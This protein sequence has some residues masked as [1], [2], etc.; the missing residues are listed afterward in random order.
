MTAS[1]LV[2][3]SDFFFFGWRVWWRS[4]AWRVHGEH[5]DAI[6]NLKKNTMDWQ[7]SSQWR[8]IVKRNKAQFT[9][10][11]K[12]LVS[13]GSHAALKNIWTY[14]MNDLSL[15]CCIS[16][17]RILSMCCEVRFYGK[18]SVGRCVSTGNTFVGMWRGVSFPCTCVWFRC[19]VRREIVKSKSFCEIAWQWFYFVIHHFHNNNSPSY[20]SIFS[21]QILK[22]NS[23]KWAFQPLGH[24]LSRKLVDFW[25]FLRSCDPRTRGKSTHVNNTLTLSVTR[26]IA[27]PH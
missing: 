2:Q 26:R 6:Q 25:L 8:S 22:L 5:V 27:V 23:S 12:F 15:L 16:R 1:R 18:T 3:Y 9:T 4:G 13:R 17:W 14:K 11:I 19:W 20:C 24:H 21:R 7:R 10:N